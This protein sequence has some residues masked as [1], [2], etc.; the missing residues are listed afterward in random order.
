M[1]HH[2]GYSM[3]PQRPLITLF[4]TP[5]LYPMLGFIPFSQCWRS[6]THISII[7]FFFSLERSLSPNTPSFRGSEWK[8]VNLGGRD[9]RWLRQCQGWLLFNKLPL[10]GLQVPDFWTCLAPFLRCCEVYDACHRAYPHPPCV[11]LCLRSFPQRFGSSSHWPLF[12]FSAELWS[13]SSNPQDAVFWQIQQFSSSPGVPQP[14]YQTHRKSIPEGDADS[15][16]KQ[17]A[18]YTRVKFHIII[19]LIFNIIKPGLQVV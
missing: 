6:L 9:G 4:F 18:K 14:F 8:R 12:E 19:Y 11:V 17:P 2:Q 1:L 15:G 10:R 5:Q 13:Y 3:S 7:S 16:S